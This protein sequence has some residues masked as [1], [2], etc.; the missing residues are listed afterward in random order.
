MNAT[1]PAT[2]LRVEGLTSANPRQTRHTNKVRTDFFE[3]GKP[4]NPIP[5]PLTTQPQQDKVEKAPTT[6][7]YCGHLPC[8][9]W[10]LKSVEDRLEAFEYYV[11]FREEGVD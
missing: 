9:R 2:A 1:T 7:K 11:T 5:T 10:G 4:Q 3:K 6:T 8:R